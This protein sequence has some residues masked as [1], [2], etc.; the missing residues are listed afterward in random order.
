MIKNNNNI[1]AINYE[2]IVSLNIIDQKSKKIKSKKIIHNN[3]SKNLFYFLCRCLTQNYSAISTPLA[4]DASLDD[5]NNESSDIES[6][7]AYRTLLSGRSVL[8]NVTIKDN[9]NMDIVYDY[10]ARFTAIVPYTTIVA[11][12]SGEHRI[13]SF[14][15]HSTLNDKTDS[16]L[17]WINLDSS[18]PISEGE[19]FLVEWN[20]GFTNPISK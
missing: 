7:L 1:N 12:S 2:G 9:N 18:I 10:V 20:M 11:T 17:A 3:G 16:L 14:Q 13:K 5:V 6:C 19:A 8:N 4:I 15:L